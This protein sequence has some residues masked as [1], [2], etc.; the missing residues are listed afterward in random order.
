MNINRIILLL[1]LSIYLG[2]I[3][4]QELIVIAENMW[5]LLQTISKTLVLKKH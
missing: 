2:T 1:F 5:M 4:G 3:G